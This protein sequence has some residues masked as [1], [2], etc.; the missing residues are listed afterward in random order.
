MTAAVSAARGDACQGEKNWFRWL[1]LALLA[2]CLAAL[3]ACGGG[4]GGSSPPPALRITAQPSDVHVVSGA[5]ATFLVSISGSGSL[6]WQR[7]AGGGGAW[8]AI[9]GATSS[10]YVTGATQDADNGAQFRVVVTPGSGAAVTSSAATLTVDPAPVAPAITVQPA[11]TSVVADQ[12][13]TFNVTATGTAI[14]YRWQRSAD[15]TNWNDVGGAPT[16][17][18]SVSGLTT[19]DNASQWRVI[20]SNSVG[21][22]T[23]AV[24][25]LT[26]LPTPQAPSFTTSPAGLSVVAGQA[27]TFSAQAVGT[28]VP[29]IAWQAS[30]DGATWTTIAGATSG[31]YTIDV[32]TLQD[33]NRR[34]RAVATNASGSVASA[35]AT[36]FVSAA[37]VA[38]AIVSS[39]ASTTASVF[40][41]ATF[42]VT[43]SGQP[44][45]TCQW[46]VS[47]DAGATFSNVNAATN[48]SL[49]VF[50]NS[51]AQD[52]WRYRAVV[53]N[54]AGSATSAAATLS[55]I[56]LPVITL[57]PANSGWRPG[58]VPG[59]F[60]GAATGAVALQWQTSTDGGN[61]WTDVAGATGTSFVYPSNGDRAVNRV[62]FV[63]TNSA[64]GTT[65]AFDAVLS[66]NDWSPVTPAVTSGQLD[67]VRWTNATTVLAAGGLGQVLRST[68]AGASWAVVAEPLLANMLGLASNGQVAIAVGAGSV[69]M[70]SPDGGAHWLTL[71][72]TGSTSALRSVAFAGS[73]ATAV[74]DA[75]TV[76][77]STDGGATWQA[78]VS[79]AGTTNLIG[80]AFNA[81]G[82]VGLAVGDSGTVLR[83]VN[84]GANW[85]S[86]RTGAESL[87]DVAFVNATTAVAVGYNGTVLRSTDAGLTWQ[88]VATG[89]SLSGVHVAFD[90]AG[91]GVVVDG[92]STQRL[93][94]SDGGAT[95]S[96][97]TGPAVVLAAAYAPSGSAA[98]AVGA[99]GELETSAD[100]GA[101]WVGRTPGN[102][103]ALRGMAFASASVG[104]VV[105]DNGTL[106]RSGDGGATWAAVAAIPATTQP[107]FGVAFP[108]AQVGIAVGANGTIWRSTDAGASWIV[109]ASGSVARLAA[110]A[111][112]SAT[113]GAAVG[114]DGM[115]YTTDAG[116]T[117]LPAS[118][119]AYPGVVSVAFA[120]PLIG[121]AVGPTDTSGLSFANGI[122]LHTADGGRTWQRE[123]LPVSVALSAVAFSDA[124][125]ATAVGSNG[126]VRSID[127][128][129][130]WTNPPE[131]AIDWVALRFTSATE[132]VSIGS[133]FFA[134][135]HDG[136]VTW[137]GGAY[138]VGDALRAV[139]VNS[140]GAAFVTTDGGSIYRNLTP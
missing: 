74:G 9:D 45:P 104:V 111:F 127:G 7:S 91:D 75:G 60:L 4:G 78:A 140:A 29:D 27:A 24:A 82:G 19:T 71:P 25:H 102:R 129:M 48:A 14:A 116:A 55:V 109:V 126:E 30:P 97:V 117:W 34:F 39:P 122:A 11:D 44:A 124:N 105:G 50:V 95:W 21:S 40:G 81:S 131:F 36:L 103:N 139:G 96:T 26:V 138:V 13:A 66:R 77:R 58:A 61:T 54:S 37:P 56:A 115:L 20:V 63:A 67:A 16:A 41:S 79:A 72:S 12:E 43:A 110:V 15:G 31:S 130:T 135:T 85:T 68:D 3:A 42:N 59:Y 35:A 73:A 128:G 101:T 10:Q 125:T 133:G 113:N 18:L 119:P 90:A 69:V 94:S 57:Q 17:T 87:R 22:V 6:Q 93:H 8:V 52:G 132:G 47:T 92:V 28:P 1:V 51:A 118:G 107:L 123:S 53:T 86:V 112:S 2:A 38:P 134:V 137:P 49:T 136:G 32:T 89:S 120:S 114:A 100:G 33:N 80:V 84:G 5:S 98:V 70:R 108:S 46:Q 106:L 64:G 62:R 83:S 121:A 76:Q 88:A 65:A 99:G 23:S